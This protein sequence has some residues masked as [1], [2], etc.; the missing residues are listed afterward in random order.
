MRSGSNCGKINDI[1]RNLLPDYPL[2]ISA[3]A[4]MGVD[5]GLPDFRGK[6][7]EGE[8][9]ALSTGSPGLHAVY[10][11]EFSNYPQVAKLMKEVEA[12]LLS[13]ITDEGLV[14]SAKNF[15]RLKSKALLAGRKPCPE[16]LKKMGLKNDSD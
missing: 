9:L 2:L 15:F 14:Q 6:P 1:V 10:L 13:E 5:S 7:R 8:V 4:G 3:G 11:D 12:N 16:L